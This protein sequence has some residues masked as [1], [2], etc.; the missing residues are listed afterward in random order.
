MKNLGDIINKNNTKITYETDIS[1][2]ENWKQLC[3]MMRENNIKINTF[4]FWFGKVTI[5]IDEQSIKKMFLANDKLQRVVITNFERGGRMLKY[6]CQCLK[7]KDLD[8]NSKLSSSQFNCKSLEMIEI[9]DRIGI[10]APRRLSELNI[11][12]EYLSLEIICVARLFVKMNLE[13]LQSTRSTRYINNDIF[14]STFDKLLK[15]VY[16]LLMTQ[17]IPIDI[18]LKFY[19]DDINVRQK[20]HHLFQSYF[21][22]TRIIKT[23]LMPK[24]NQHCIAIQTPIASFVLDDA[25][26]TALFTVKN[27]RQV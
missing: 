3:N 26:K 2:H 15:I 20:C 4:K 21:D 12:V 14:I 25:K 10:L 22:Q 13:L 27:A 23:Y 8:S 5:R 24:C 18:V 9:K 11:I 6:L 17:M 16:N 7:V 19:I 1:Q